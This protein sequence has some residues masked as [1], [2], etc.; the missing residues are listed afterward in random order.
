V[1]RPGV[2]VRTRKGY[3]ATRR[4]D[5]ARAAASE[6]G[7]SDKKQKKG[8]SNKRLLE[9]SLL[10]GN[11]RGGLPVR[12]GAYVMDADDAGSTRIQVVV[13]IDNGSV[14][15]DRTK[16]PWKAKL[17]LTVMAASLGRPPVVPVDEE[18]ELSLEPGQVGSGWWLVQREL[19][20]P[21]GVAHVRVLVRDTA[22]DALGLVTERL[23]VPAADQPYVSTPLVTDRAVPGWADG[24]LRL[25]AAARRSFSRGPQVFCEYEVFASGRR[26]AGREP[27]LFG[28]Y[29]LQRAD[30]QV[31]SAEDGTPIKSDGGRAVRRIAFPI[32]KL[33]NGSYELA[34]VVGD[35]VSRRTMVA[36]SVFEVARP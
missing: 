12:L 20:L 21:P 22:S 15:V 14:Q 3:L 17:K 33:E 36:R 16:T 34:V 2:S 18:L 24:P 19:R 11:A 27:Q 23:V 5:L 26:S 1:K 6:Q 31:V 8:A 9:P 32:G 25:V 7:D 29:V 28:G 4:Q 13:E 30:G 10:A 35:L